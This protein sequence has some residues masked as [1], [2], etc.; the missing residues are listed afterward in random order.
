M[1]DLYTRPGDLSDPFGLDPPC[2]CG[3]SWGVLTLENGVQVAR[4]VACHRALPDQPGPPP[5]ASPGEA[6]A[7]IKSPST[8]A[9]VVDKRRSKAKPSATTTRSP[10][11]RQRRKSPA[12]LAEDEMVEIALGLRPGPSISKTPPEE[13]RR[14]FELT[15]SCECGC[16][17][18]TLF[19]GEDDLTLQC[20]G[21]GRILGTCP[22]S[23]E[24][25]RG[26]RR[27]RFAISPIAPEGPVP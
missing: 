2:S 14:P 19:A 3:S 24:T 12:E 11:R 9:P 7:D 27:P 5:D 1:F 21:C 13:D 18:A 26:P 22:V 25:R 17:K 8:S 15:P 23:P 16:S 10:R 6:T 20:D 4:C